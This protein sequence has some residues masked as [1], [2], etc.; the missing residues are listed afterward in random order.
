MKYTMII[1]VYRIQG[2]RLRNLKFNLNR[3]EKSNI[4]CKVVIAEQKSDIRIENEIIKDFDH[5]IFDLDSDIFHK[6]RLMNIASKKVE[7]DWFWFHDIDVYIPYKKVFEE[8]KKSEGLYDAI[9]PYLEVFNL[10]EEHTEN[11]I[12]NKSVNI[13]KSDNVK[14]FSEFSG[15]SFL[16]KKDKFIDLGMWNEDFKGWGYEDKHMSKLCKMKLKTKSIDENAV[17]L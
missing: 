1:P 6:T 7:C 10:N 8:V 11:F 12:E 17:H 2:L 13:T 5:F 16:I 3:I 9:S 14:K 15:G 4:D